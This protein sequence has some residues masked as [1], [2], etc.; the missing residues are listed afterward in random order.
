MNDGLRLSGHISWTLIGKDGSI[1]KG[2]IPNIIT[3]YGKQWVPSILAGST[4]SIW[5]AAGSSIGSNGTVSASDASLF[6][7]VS[8]N[9]YGYARSSMS[10]TANNN[11]IE[12]SAF[13]AGITSPITI[14]EVGLFPNSS[15]GSTFLI[16]HQI[17]GQI[18]MGPTYAGLQVTWIISFN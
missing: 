4:N 12:Y 10:K 8:S 13:I 5:L 17:V 15:V 6:S 7:E 11:T 18:P 2:S 9:G 3:N 14:R 1:Q 16:A